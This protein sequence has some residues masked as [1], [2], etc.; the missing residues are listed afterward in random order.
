MRLLIRRK[1][2]EVKPAGKFYHI[3]AA[4]TVRNWDNTW[5]GFLPSQSQDVRR[6]QTGR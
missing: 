2:A 5:T 3:K 1:R 6:G 4:T